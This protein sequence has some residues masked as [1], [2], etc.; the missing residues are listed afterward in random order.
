ML[1]MRIPGAQIVGVDINPRA[2]K[3]GNGLFTQEEIANVRLA[4]ISAQTAVVS[5]VDALSETTISR[6]G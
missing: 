6:F 3:K 4:C 1:A 2:V 5:S